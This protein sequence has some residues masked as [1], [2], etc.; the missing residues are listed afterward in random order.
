MDIEFFFKFMSTQFI[1]INIQYK[2]RYYDCSALH[3]I[4]WT[5]AHVQ[6][7]FA[8]VLNKTWMYISIPVLYHLISSYIILYPSHTQC[9]FTGPSWC[10]CCG[11]F[12]LRCHPGGHAEDPRTGEAKA[13]AAGS[14]SGL[15]SPK[16]EVMIIQYLTHTHI[17]CTCNTII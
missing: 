11:G 2:N 3:R 1:C 17:L 14:C 9:V 13:G 15:P 5:Y 4:A 16:T 12:A 8:F 10:G 7:I 6:C